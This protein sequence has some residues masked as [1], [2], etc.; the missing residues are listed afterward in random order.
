MTDQPTFNRRRVLEL[1]G[2]GT[3][4]AIAG[5]TSQVDDDGVEGDRGELADD[6]RRVT[7]AVQ[8]D[9][10]DQAELQQRQMQLQQQ[11]QQGELDEQEVQ[12]EQAE[13]Q[14]L[15]EELIEGALETVRTEFEAFDLTIEDT[16]DEGVLLVAGPATDLIDAVDLEIIQALAGADLFEQAQQAQ[17]QPAPE[18]GQ[19]APE[20]GEAVPE[21]EIEE[22]IEEELEG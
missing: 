18:E 8:I 12:A 19:P 20:D 21:E 22:E 10:Q 2:V 6:E 5:C 14:E 17:Q 4:L 15:Q 7:M 9:E 1:S 3:T 13:L 16:L 11:A